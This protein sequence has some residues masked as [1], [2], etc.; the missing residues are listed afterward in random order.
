MSERHDVV[1]I[2]AGI[3]GLCA[4]FAL[5]RRGRS[6]L[7]VDRFEAGHDRGGSHG[8]GRI[9]RSS[10]HD[11]RYVELTKQMHQ[12]AWPELEAAL[13]Q[14]LVHPTPGVFFGPAD[15]PFGAF[16]DATLAAGVDVE[17]I[18]R[19]EAAARFDLLRFEP[20]DRVMLD[21]TAGVLAAE[22]TT[23]GLRA[24][25]ATHGVEVRHEHEVTGLEP[26]T[27]GVALASRRGELVAARVVVAAGAWLGRLLPEWRAE[28]VPLRQEVG[29]VDVEAPTA[30]TAVGSFPVW[31]RI[32]RDAFDYGLPEFGRP[33]LKIAQ[34]RT[35]GAPDDPDDDS[36][37]VDEGALIARAER[38]FTAPV[39]SLRGVE[40]CLYT[41]APGE[42]LHVRP[43]AQDPR[44]V[45][46]A[47]CSG[48]GFKFAPVLAEQVADLVEA[49]GT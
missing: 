22:R 28:L 13:G 46:V 39:R 25:L 49:A 27:D 6:V 30:R 21:H 26:R 48:H 38:R 41:V 36:G 24:W 40:S 15:G 12:R 32:S 17:E 45:A 3:H 16:L 20:D 8:S 19:D 18:P 9:T 5:R 34:H 44:V 1:V 37:G 31:C 10:Y 2:G 47:A 42:H 11:R 33:G 4:A 14:Q 43:H 35:V 7:V 29:Y 23:T